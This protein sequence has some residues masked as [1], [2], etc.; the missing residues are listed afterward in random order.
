MKQE[1]AYW[2][3]PNRLTNNR[4]LENDADS[5]VATRGVAMGSKVSKAREG[6]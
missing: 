2:D 6:I 1:T 5:L 4:W 3:C